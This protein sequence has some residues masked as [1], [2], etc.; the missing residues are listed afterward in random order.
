VY[1]PICKQNKIL[2]TYRCGYVS[3]II[4]LLYFKKGDICHYESRGKW[5]KIFTK[6]DMKMS[7]LTIIEVCVAIIATLTLN[8]ICIGVTVWDIKRGDFDA[9]GLIGIAFVD[10]I[11]FLQFF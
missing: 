7:V 3:T 2:F 5:D 6:G 10:F 9:R 8:V 1:Y 4:Y 11:L